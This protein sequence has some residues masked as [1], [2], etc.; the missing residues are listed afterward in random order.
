MAVEELETTVTKTPAVLDKKLPRRNFL[1][2]LGFL[3]N[4]GVKC[5]EQFAFHGWPPC[6]KRNRS[7]WGR[8]VV[9]VE[10]YLVG[11]R[12]CGVPGE[13]VK[14]LLSLELTG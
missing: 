3:L 1:I 4:D 9:H 5:Q 13:G 8:T 12:S 10:G 2:K 7:V 6:E 14:T 11:E